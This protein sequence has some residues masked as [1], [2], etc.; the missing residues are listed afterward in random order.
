VSPVPRT[1]CLVALAAALAPGGAFGQRRRPQGQGLPQ[2]LLQSIYPLGVNAGGTVEVNVRGSDLEGATALWFDHPGLRAFHVKGTMFRVACATGAAPGHHDVRAVG[3]YGV[4]NPRVF[5]V[6]DRPEA[7]EAEPN[8]TPNNASPVAVNSVVNGEVATGADIDCFAVEARKGQRLLFDLEAERVDSRLDATL[9][10][11]D[12]R[13]REVGESRDAFGADPF[14]DFTVPA[15]GR[16]VV[17]V[18]DVTYKGSSDHAYR[19]TVTDGPH[20]DAVVPAIARAGETAEFTLIG[21]NLGGEPAPDLATDGRPLERKTVTLT[22]PASFDSEPPLGLVASAG[23]ARRGFA[24]ALDSPSGRSNPLWVAEASDPV[25]TEREPNGPEHPQ[26]VSVPCDVSGTFGAPGDLDVYR[27][28]AKKG[29]VFW[30]EAAAERIGSPADPSFVVQKVNA[31]GETQDVAA[32]DDTPDRGALTRFPTASADASVRFSAPEDGLYQVAVAD[33]YGSQ[34]GDARLAYRLNVRPERPDFRLFLLPESDTLPDALTLGAGGRALATVF[35]DRVDGFTGPVEVEAVDLP[36][37]VRC[38]PVVVAAGQA[39]G[40]VV[41]EAAGDAKSVVGTARLVGRSRFGDRKDALSYRSGVATLG[42]DRS[43]A[44][45]GGAVVWPAAP[46]Q[47]GPALAAARLTRGFVVMVVDPSPLALS[48]RPAAGVVVAG[49][50]LV[51][52]V[53]VTR[54]A[55]FAGAVSVSPVFP[56]PGVSA[57]AVTIAPAAASGSFVLPT[58]K[59]LATGVYTLALVGTGPYPFSKDPKAKTK[60]NVTLSEPANAVVFTV[61][62]AP[63]SVAVGKPGTLKAGGSVALD[64]TVTRKDGSADPVT[65]SLVAPAGLKLAADPVAAT[66]GKAARLVVN[67]AA[68][69]PVGAA[70][71]VVVR[72][73]IP[74][75]GEPVGVDELVALS[76]VK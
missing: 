25:V 36:P 72:A 74:V 61:R 63:G 45:A 29:D 64:V 32:G 55:G 16:Y 58:P 8:D 46:S 27:F 76:V 42:P 49:S 21:R 69:S 28:A 11:L 70:A 57:P 39:V 3:P 34:R 26:T 51:V 50:P 13:G 65:V 44:A 7:R 35:V 33:L 19:L 6:G 43:H 60:P 1:L 31:K 52:D 4:S 5:V 14:L 23:A 62:P 17:K 18:H 54:R 53:R 38:D 37:G 30:V 75:R 71:G 48:A 12:P 15:D 22:P 41:F 2:P 56:P 10:L 24:Y 66:P 68:D 40:P 73:E 67:A 47:Q 59:T 9:R 20:L